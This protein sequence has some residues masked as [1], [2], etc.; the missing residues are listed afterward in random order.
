MKDMG[1]IDRTA[2]S[3]KSTAI[4]IASANAAAA[5]ETTERDGTRHHNVDPNKHVRHHNADPNKHGT[6]P[7]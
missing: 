3:I 5:G 1:E 6:K 4:N 7:A 2:K